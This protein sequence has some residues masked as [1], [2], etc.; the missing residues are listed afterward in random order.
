MI[1][2]VGVKIAMIWQCCEDDDEKK[3]DIERGIQ[4][5]VNMTKYNRVFLISQVI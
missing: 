5:R 1:V 3:E 2:V 4:T